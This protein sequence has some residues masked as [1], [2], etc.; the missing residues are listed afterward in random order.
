M[1]ENMRNKPLCYACKKPISLKTDLTIGSIYPRFPIYRMFHS[2]HYDNFMLKGKWHKN[3]IKTWKPAKYSPKLLKT[4]DRKFNRQ[5]GFTYMNFFHKLGIFKLNSI[6]HWIMSLIYAGL[7]Y[8]L[9]FPISNLGRIWL[10]MLG[11]LI[12]IGFIY[13]IIVLIYFYQKYF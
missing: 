6:N 13:E 2:K 9:L 1:K 11:T 5:I 3:I 12:I 7:V 8:V 10:Y 4:Y